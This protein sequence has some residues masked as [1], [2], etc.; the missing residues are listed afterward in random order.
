[1]MK[2]GGFYVPEECPYFPR[3]IAACDGKLDEETVQ[4]ALKFTKERRRAVDVGA[5]VGTW[6]R[7]LAGVF[8][9]VV[10]FEPYSV[11]YR[12]L[13]A[14]LNEIGNVIALPIALGSHM[15]R[16]GVCSRVQNSGQ[17]FVV[18][19]EDGTG[20]WAPLMRLDDFALDCVD[21]IKI[22]AEGF[23]QPVVAGALET[24]LACK[25][26][27]VIEENECPKR[28]G[29]EPDAATEL[30]KSHGAKEVG[31]IEFEKGNFNVILAWTE[32]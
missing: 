23:E 20:T 6:T 32:E 1:M 21:L 16:V 19:V 26:V 18:P 30:L 2:A 9:E 14:N 13:L 5:H 3:R 11:V 28:Y 25:P 17:S 27:V 22:D 15:D 29:R 7:Q 31:R 10:A 24:I 4:E 8:G 12:Y